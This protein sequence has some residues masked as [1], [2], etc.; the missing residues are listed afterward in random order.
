MAAALLPC[1]LTYFALFFP[2]E[3][4][5]LPLES[6]VRRRWASPPLQLAS[7]AAPPREARGQARDQAAVAPAW[8]A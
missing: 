1:S 3:L 6:Q 7:P 2:P 8:A 5:G 4:I